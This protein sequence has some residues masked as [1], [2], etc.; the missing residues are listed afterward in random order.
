MN[1]ISA[2]AHADLGR[3]LQKIRR[4]AG[5]TQQQVSAAL[6]RPQSFVSK[7]EMAE[8]KLNVVELIEVCAV[9]RYRADELVQALA[10]TYL[11]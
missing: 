10:A 6:G 9:L 5:L 2:N 1:R 7:Y 8:R 11:R 3:R 4:D